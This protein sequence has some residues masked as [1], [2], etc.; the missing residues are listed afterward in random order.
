[1]RADVRRSSEA[2][3]G[4]MTLSSRIALDI[5]LRGG[6][7]LAGQWAFSRAWDA[8][9]GDAGGPDIGAGLVGFALVVGA[10][11]VWGALDGRRHEIGR[12]GV[13]WVGA[14]LVPA[15]FFVVALGVQDG[16]S[17]AVL[18]ADLAVLAPLMTALIAVPAV[19]AGALSHGI[20]RRT[21]VRR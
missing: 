11:F 5:A 13:T 14:G 8:V 7:F 20:G 21:P 4:Q 19:V 9:T 17:R 6:L 1:M 3:A 12:L 15:V 16:V 2:H 10:A 18:L